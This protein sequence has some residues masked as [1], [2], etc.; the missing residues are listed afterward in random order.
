MGK[1]G[2]FATASPGLKHMVP[3]SNRMN[4]QGFGRNDTRPDFEAAVLGLPV[5]M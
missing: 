4:D 1:D 2:L 5:R 3:A